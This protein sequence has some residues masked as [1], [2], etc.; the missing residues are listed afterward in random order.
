MAI[1]VEIQTFE[2]GEI[3]PRQASA[4][5]TSEPGLVVQRDS[6]RGGKWLPTWAVTHRASGYRVVGGFRT[7]QAALG[8][9]AEIAAVADWTE[10]RETLLAQAAELTPKLRLLRERFKGH[11]V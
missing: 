9:A 1:R 11:S 6:G 7:R 8:Y 5:L 2:D 10:D 3:R 4:Y